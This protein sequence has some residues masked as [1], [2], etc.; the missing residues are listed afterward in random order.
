[1]PKNFFTLLDSYENYPAAKSLEP[2][3]EPCEFDTRRHVANRHRRKRE[4]E[5]WSGDNFLAVDSP[6]KLNFVNVARTLV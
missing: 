4:L 2:D 1:M 6:A 5:F 3:G